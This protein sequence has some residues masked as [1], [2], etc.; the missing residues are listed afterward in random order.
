[1]LRQSLLTSYQE[2]SADECLEGMNRHVE[3][4][5]GVINSWKLHIDEKI[6]Q[7]SALD[8]FKGYTNQHVYLSVFLAY[9]IS[10]TKRFEFINLNW[11]H[12]VRGVAW[13]STSVDEW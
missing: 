3:R 13:F 11:Q 8:I 4:N 5:K 1:M 7:S 6:Y 10:L 12:F 2:V 9:L